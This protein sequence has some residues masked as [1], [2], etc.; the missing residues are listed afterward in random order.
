MKRE[1]VLAII[2]DENKSAEEKR[3]AIMTLN[4]ADITREK[5]AANSLSEKI[6]SLESDLAGEREKASK[7]SNYD[8]IVKERD[9]LIAEKAERGIQDRF[10]TCLGSKK[11]KNDFTK[12][13][14]YEA[15]KTA[16]SDE[17]NK[18]KKDADIWAG[19]VGGKEAE[20]FDGV[21]IQM[22]G[23][24]TKISAQTDEIKA[25]MD[26]AY[27]NNPFYSPTN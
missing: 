23:V 13:G 11:P 4:G 1:E 21:S 6:K 27:K 22:H 9:G 19:I 10:A 8:E 5:N 16:I 24:N 2:N 7:Y 14:L 18:E 25:Y 20:L 17:A 12:S 15:F 3:D 26:E